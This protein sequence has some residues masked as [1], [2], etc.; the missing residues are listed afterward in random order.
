MLKVERINVF[1]GDMQALWDISF[2]V[3]EGKI[4][5]IVGSNG[6]G[7]TTSLSTI[8]G[9]KHPKSGS[10]TFMDQPIEKFQPHRVVELGIAQ[11]AEGRK[12]FSQMS[13]LE[14]L[15]MGTFTKKA[16][17]YMDDSLTWVFDL[18][19]VL[20]A[21]RSQ[22]AGTLSGG[23]QQMV[24][25]ARALMSRPKLLMLDEPSF[26]LAPKIVLL[27]FETIK[28]VRE[29]GLTILLVE[30]NVHHALELADQGYTLETGRIT[31]EGTGASLLEDEYIKK[32]YLGM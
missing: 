10:I 30:Q 29:E 13:V 4:V 12:L 3:G 24:A 1:Y 2:Q 19:P 6:A 31:K 21:R 26:G 22:S 5:T 32:T 27:V 20:R 17:P 11:I 18:F 16:R 15:Q 8:S 9:L 25:I 23:E 28:R 14:N 7:K